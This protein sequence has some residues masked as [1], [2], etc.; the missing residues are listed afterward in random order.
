MSWGRSLQLSLSKTH[1]H[2]KLLLA[3]LGGSEP[4]HSIHEPKSGCYRKADTRDILDVKRYQL[5]Q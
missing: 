2:A 4:K 3:C 5:Q 1:R